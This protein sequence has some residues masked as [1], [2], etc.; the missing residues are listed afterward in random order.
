MPLEDLFSDPSL[1]YVLML[2]A[3]GLIGIGLIYDAITFWRRKGKPM[4]KSAAVEP[5]HENWKQ[6][7]ERDGDEGDMVKVPRRVLVQLQE[8]VSSLK[9]IITSVTETIEAR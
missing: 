4:K 9:R 2:V 3:C 6:E 5:G 7:E 8:E 1:Y